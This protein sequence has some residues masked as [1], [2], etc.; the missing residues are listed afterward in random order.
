MY[1]PK[2]VAFN[3]RGIYEVYAG[4]KH[5]HYGKQ[6]ELFLGTDTHVFVMPSSS[7]RCSQLPRAEDKLPFYVGLRKL[8]DFLNGTLQSLNEADI[9]FPDI[10]IKDTDD[11]LQKT[12]IRISNKAFSELSP[13]TLKTYGDKIPSGQMTSKFNFDTETTQ[14]MSILHNQQNGNLLN[15]DQQTSSTNGNASSKT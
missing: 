10:K 9:T 12:I 13:E 5:F 2:I 3:G 8:R 14:T 4:N 1:R 15:Y 6:P 7:A 11:V